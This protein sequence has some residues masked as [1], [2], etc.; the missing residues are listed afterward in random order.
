M[1]CFR[2]H[3]VL[4]GRLESEMELLL[5]GHS[6]C[7]TNVACQCSTW[8]VAVCCVHKSCRNGKQLYEPCVCNRSLYTCSL[9][10]SRRW[11]Y[12]NIVCMWHLNVP[13]E[14]LW[15]TID[16]LCA[17]IHTLKA[18]SS[19]C[20]SSNVAMFP[21]CNVRSSSAKQSLIGHIK[22]MSEPCFSVAADVVA[23]MRTLALCLLTQR[24][25]NWL[26]QLAT[27]RM[28]QYIKGTVCRGNEHVFA[29]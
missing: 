3:L 10:Y 9:Y 5:L 15:K 8:H 26:L 22:N 11:I 19:S 4:Y 27:T 13:F 7:V 29:P 2:E 17:H 20:R 16:S 23:I 14:I 21:P 18:A 6:N 12:R 24:F 1:S 25:L 28:L